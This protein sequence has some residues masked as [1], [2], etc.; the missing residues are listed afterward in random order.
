MPLSRYQIRNE[1]SLADPELYRAADKDDPEALLEGVAMTGLVGVLRQL[2]DLAEF[3]AEIFHD[4]HEEV[5]STAARGHS[6]TIRVQQLEAEMPSIEKA[7]LS[8]TSHSSFFYNSGTDWHP[9][10]RMD[11]NM[12][13]QGDLPRF[14]MDSYEECRGPPR[15]FLLDKFDIAGA[16]ACQKRYTDPSFF[17]EAASSF[18]MTNAD[19]QREKRTRKAKK[20]GSRWRNGETPEVLPTSHAKLHQLFLEEERIENG[21]ND[22]GRRVKLKRR[23]NGFPFDSKTGKSYMEKFL[24]TTSPEHVVHEV[25]VDSSPLKLPASSAYEIGLDYVETNAT[26]A[27]EETTHTKLSMSPSLSPPQSEE[28]DAIKQPNDA[29][30]EAVT[31]IVPTFDKVS[32]GNEI[33]DG[34][35]KREDSTNGYHSDDIVSEVENYVDAVASMDSE[36]DTDSELRARI[37]S[38]FLNREKPLSTNHDQIQS[39]S[40]D[41]Q[42]ISNS[43][44]SDDANSTSKK[45]VS[46]FSSG[47]P[48]TSVE[49]APLDGDTAT[50]NEIR[51][52][53][54]CYSPVDLQPNNEGVA[55][56]QPSEQVVFSETSIV[57]AEHLRQSY[58]L[59]PLSMSSL[60][61][62]ALV[63]GITEAG[64]VMKEDALVKPTAN[65]MLS[66]LDEGENYSTDVAETAANQHMNV[67]APICSDAPGQM[68]DD[69]PPIVSAEN[70]L[71]DDIHTVDLSMG[72]N[73]TSSKYSD[74]PHDSIDDLPADDQNGDNSALDNLNLSNNMFTTSNP[75][76]HQKRDESLSTENKFLDNIDG[77]VLDS[78]DN[79][80]CLDNLSN[81]STSRKDGHSPSSSSI[82]YST[83]EFDD[84]DQNISSGVSVRLPNMLEASSEEEC[85]KHDLLVAP[86]EEN[87]EDD[88][89]KI[90]E[91]HSGSLN[92]PVVQT[93][94]KAL[95]SASEIENTSVKFDETLVSEEEYT[96]DNCTANSDGGHIG[97]SNL[98]IIQTVPLDT[99]DVAYS[100]SR[101]VNLD[102]APS[103]TNTEDKFQ[104]VPGPDLI[105]MVTSSLSPCLDSTSEE[106]AGHVRVTQADRL[107]AEGAAASL[108]SS[109]ECTGGASVSSLDIKQLQDDSNSS[110]GHCTLNGLQR[111]N[112]FLKD[113]SK[114]SGALN[115]IGHHTVMYDL[116][117]IAGYNHLESEVLT[118]DL[119]KTSSMQLPFEQSTL[120]VEET[121][122]PRSSFKDVIGD[123]SPLQSHPCAEQESELPRDQLDNEEPLDYGEKNL[124]LIPPLEQELSCQSDQAGLFGA[125]SKYVM[126]N[127][128][129]QAP[130]PEDKCKDAS[131]LLIS[132]FAEHKAEIAHNQLHKEEL[133]VGNGNAENTLLLPQLE[134]R[135]PSYHTELERSV[136]LSSIPVTSEVPIQCSFP[137]LLAQGNHDDAS[138]LPTH[139]CLEENVKLTCNQIEKEQLVVE[140]ENISEQLYKLEKIEAPDHVHQEGFI[141]ASS[142]TMLNGLPCKPSVS[143]LLPHGNNGIGLFPR[144]DQIN[145]EEMPPLPP[146]PPVQWRIGKFQRVQERDGAQNG[147]GSLPSF[148]SQ[149]DQAVQPSEKSL[150]LPAVTNEDSTLVYEYGAAHYGSFTLQAPHRIIDENSKENLNVPTGKQPLDS[151]SQVIPVD[152]ACTVALGTSSEELILPVKQTSETTEDTCL[153]RQELE[154]GLTN[155]EGNQTTNNRLGQ[156]V[157]PE[158]SGPLDASQL[159]DKELTEPPH[160]VALVTSM[161]EAKID[162]GSTSLEDNLVTDKELIQPEH[163]VAPEMS[164]KEL[165]LDEDSSSS[166]VNLVTH[167]TM[168]SDKEPAPETSLNEQKLDKAHTISEENL[169]SH[170]TIPVNKELTPSEHQVAPEVNSKEL[171]SEK[172]SA[173]LEENLVVDDAL[174]LAMEMNFQKPLQAKSSLEEDIIWP[175]VEDGMVNGSRKMKLPRPRTP[176]IEAVAAHDKSK[177]RKVTDRVMPPVQ[178]VDERD[179]VLEHDKSKLRKV[180]DRVKPP[181]QKVDERDMLLEQ[182]RN[183]SF[184]LKPASVTRPNIQAPQ[185]NLRVAAILEKAKTIRQAFAGSDE[186]DDEDSWD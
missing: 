38:H 154:K 87:A 56:A 172:S 88:C 107:N 4:L 10:L 67:F 157:K 156:L 139:D 155:S 82:N 23:L 45:E 52:I 8:Q 68:R 127:I 16:G 162:K 63:P 142:K 77:E 72:K 167:D 59:E 101:Q 36:L 54:M 73:I 132:Q 114:D 168:P 94:N 21:T 130:L 89:L 34:Q 96:E 55:S 31:V 145:L 5:M 113:D 143:K 141:D 171:E 61:D 136:N 60:L 7:F 125:S 158:D 123:A 75:F 37:H 30:N 83:G 6:L 64:T 103:M 102:E 85:V 71:L 74:V 49:T 98:S 120:N 117:E 99:R 180:T 164:L 93:E 175:A 122:S 144:S 176:L 105:E 81:H 53:Q 161:E 138:S 119:D 40:S 116:H 166:E 35:D 104:S 70:Q 153:K 84:G 65:E 24:R 95:D 131:S 100:Q 22:S 41:S 66:T 20:K 9:N 92:L 29:L 118:L 46:S 86:E 121:S 14:V 17:K 12:V 151:S 15:L 58:D 183:K 1:F 181:V 44:L 51:E 146:L 185:P 47:S 140:D 106:P 147:T 91:D 26:S 182:I 173:C 128:P 159:S 150:P 133:L 135:Q 174:R 165:K 19:F 126:S 76:A 13:T 43:T 111:E 124:N 163:Q 11:Q 39:Q 97:P 186:E 152:K 129:F 137:K 170:N 50:I 32:T 149:I 69:L 177:L 2:G 109:D 169:V 25:S 3:A 179:M 115:E 78:V 148:P 27:D 48:S 57:A 108:G 134:Q 79:T 112:L 110:S 160:Q 28:N 42:S 90:S 62:S 80:N 184:N 18:E 33:I 178:K